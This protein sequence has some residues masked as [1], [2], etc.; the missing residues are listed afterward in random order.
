MTE[1]KKVIYPSVFIFIWCLLSNPILGQAYY[2]S[3]GNASDC[4]GNFYDTGNDNPVDPLVTSYSANENYTF[5]LCPGAG[6][7]GL[8]S[9]V[10]F[11]TFDLGLGDTLFIYDGNSISSPLIGAF[12]GNS[13]ATGVVESNFGCL[14]FVFISDGVD[15]GGGWSGTIDCLNCQTILPNANT[16]SAQDPAT[17]FIDICSGDNLTFEAAPEFPENGLNYTQA[18]STSSFEWDLFVTTSTNANVSQTYNTPG[19]F[20]VYFTVA[21]VNGCKNRVQYAAVRVSGEPNFAGTTANDF[22]VCEG[23]SFNLIGQVETEKYSFIYGD[24]GNEIFLPDGSGV[25]YGSELAVNEFDIGQTITSVS[26]IQTICINME[27]SYMGDLDLEVECPDGSSVLLHAQGGGGTFLGE[28]EESDDFSCTL[29]CLPGVGYE[30][31][32][33]PTSGNGTWEDNSDSGN[34][35]P[36]G[37]YEPVENFSNFTGCPLNGEWV[38]N[39]TDNLA[40]DN[41]TIFSWYI[42]FDE[43]LYSGTV[44]SFQPVIEEEKWS[45]NGTLLGTGGTVSAIASP[46]GVQSFEYT[47]TDNFGC[48]WDTL[49]D[50]EVVPAP[51]AIISHNNACEDDQPIVF[52]ESSAVNNAGAFIDSYE[53]NFGVGSNIFSQNTQ[54]TFPSSGSFPVT[55]KV[56]DSEGCEGDT[57]IDVTIFPK[58][59]AQFINDPGCINAEPIFFN[60]LSTV[61]K[62]GIIEWLWSFG[63]GFSELTSSGN[64]NHSYSN[65]QQ[66]FATLVVTSDSG[67]K[68]TV[69]KQVEVF[70]KPNAFFVVDKNES[71]MPLCVNTTN[72]STSLTTS[73]VKNEWFFGEGSASFDSDPNFCYEDDGGYVMKLVVQNGY[74]CYDTISRNMM[75]HP[76]P[77]PDFRYQPVDYLTSLNPKSKFLDQTDAASR[78]KWFVDGE[79]LYS[80]Q[81]PFHVFSTEGEFP[82]MLE[83]TNRFGCVD[84][85]E[86]IVTVL[87]VTN[88]YVPNT[89]SPNNDDLNDVFQITGNGVKNEEFQFVLRNR[90]GDI[91]WESSSLRDSWDGT[92]NGKPV[93]QDVY[94]YTLTY[95]DVKGEK[96]IVNGT[97]S[98]IR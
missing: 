22:E 34:S 90:W 74:G 56:I 52:T 32:F 39:I 12:T 55:L 73:I 38:L 80:E 54:F 50:V 2:I 16:S 75:V 94:I 33:S 93:K 18:I 9:E 65:D 67:C 96:N 24:F 35:L 89:F 40:S 20:P 70:E 82:V 17:G 79:F 69:V 43:S 60:D 41:G 4:S 30:Y 97:L 86:K 13:L 6:S 10:R 59:N 76:L 58:P 53:W 11:A 45:L 83:A 27:H 84:S 3:D 42:G 21:D 47:V 49:I 31:C 66:Y 77:I 5:T 26:D 92:K 81:N 85:I 48:E 57:T 78:W 19:Y 14:T 1:F 36:E 95:Y 68:D 25:S 64:T 98:V 51:T 23:A 8:K 46:Q 63:D 72:V 7:T 44:P 61:S 87:P 15:E 62:G 91:V 71:C 88:V 29:N 37:E 28:P